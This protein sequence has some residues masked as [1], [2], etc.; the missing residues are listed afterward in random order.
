MA[1]DRSIS[2][3]VVAEHDTAIQTVR[4]LLRQLGCA[5]IDDANSIADALATMRIKRYRLVISD[6][7]AAAS[8]TGCDLLRE[9]RSDAALNRIP[10][11]ITGESN[12]S[13]VIAAK[14]A[15]VNAYIVKPFDAQT[16]KVKIEAAFALY[17][18]PLPERPQPAA[19][20]QSPRVCEPEASVATTTSV[21][22]R[23]KVEGIFTVSLK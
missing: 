9:V 16:L 2:V 20:S 11:L 1:F 18:M 21:V 8:T 5:D 10:F 23:L 22:D 19:V 7:H 14:R 17:A 3:L 12:S 15:G 6:W 4:T 13:H